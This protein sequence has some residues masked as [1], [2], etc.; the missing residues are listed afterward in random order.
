[1]KLVVVTGTKSVNNLIVIVPFVVFIIATTSQ[2]S[3]ALVCI[4][5]IFVSLLVVKFSIVPVACEPV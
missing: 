1:M 2:F 3:S 5:V 4:F